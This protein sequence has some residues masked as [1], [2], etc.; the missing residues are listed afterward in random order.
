MEKFKQWIVSHKL[1]AI[2]IASVLAVGIILA[3]V[4]PI[5]LNQHTFSESWSVDSK[6]HWHMCTDEGCAKTKDKQQ[7]DFDESSKCKVCQKT[8]FVLVLDAGDT[9]YEIGEGFFQ[10][11]WITTCSGG[12]EYGDIN[13]YYTCEYFKYSADGET[14]TSIGDSAPT[15]AGRYMLKVVFAGDETYLPAEA[16]TDFTVVEETN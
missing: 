3:I 13:S 2:I 7:H 9:P 4:L 12:S 5:A 11:N 8:E 15:E 6:Y 16:T 14:L 1:I 10:T